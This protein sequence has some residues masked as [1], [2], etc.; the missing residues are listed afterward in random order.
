[1]CGAR[2]LSKYLSALRQIILLRF[3]EA[4]DQPRIRVVE[5]ITLAPR[6]SLVM[7]DVDGQ[8]LLVSLVQGT[9]S[10]FFQLDNPC[11]RKSQ[12]KAKLNVRTMP[13]QSAQKQVGTPEAAGRIFARR[14]RKMR[15]L[16]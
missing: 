7:L 2:T 12:A 8:R 13:V 6:H 9:Q 14:A 10:S 16:V 15:G 1:M 5:K 4:R 11:T 3:K